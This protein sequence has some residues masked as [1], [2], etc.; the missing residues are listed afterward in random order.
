MFLALKIAIANLRSNVG[1]TLLSALGIVIGIISIVV[2]LTLGKGVE[3]FVSGQIESFGTDV[4]QVEVKVPSTKQMSSSN[5]GSLAG[6]TQITTFKLEDAEAVAKLPNIEA[7]Y[8]GQIGQK[9]A[10]FEEKSKQ[11]L[12]WGTTSGIE[13]AD[14]NFEIT[15]GTMFSENDD[16]S[17]RQTVVL[18]SKLKE[19]FFGQKNAAGEKIKLGN[20]AYT[21]S[22]VLAPKG[23]VSFFDFDEVAY[24]PIQ[25]MQKKILGIDHVGFAIFKLEDMEKMQITKFQ[26]EETMRKQHN[27]KKDE[28]EDFA[29]TSI[30]QANEIV[31]KVFSAINLLLIALSSIS[32][33]IGGVGITNVMYV[34]V[35]ERSFEIGLRKSLGARKSDILRQFITESIIVTLLGGLLGIIFGFLLSWALEWLI[36]KQGYAL[37][38]SLNSQ[39]IIISLVFSV[40]TG[41]IFG[42]RPAQK[43]ASL[44]PI[45][46]MRKE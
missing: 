13:K 3:N 39:S 38:L 23:S 44:S 5:A 20:K 29:V 14:P 21:V 6:G 41:I 17:L 28:D 19:Y 32:L 11:I 43:A 45:E 37:D 34:A 8:A 25:T 24:V 1:R 22:G 27:I 9:A 10:S 18:G 35:T 4:V 46:A 15:E 12:L 16:D 2:V 26:I 40:L 30:A 33:I 36:A 42:I 7:W 31:E